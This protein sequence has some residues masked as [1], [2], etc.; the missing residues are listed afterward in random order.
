MPGGELFSILSAMHFLV[1]PVAVFYTA[2]VTAA[3]EHLHDRQIAYRDLK[4]EN[5]LLDAQG[6]LK[7]VDFGFAKEV[8]TKT[9]TLC[10]TPEYLAP[11][12]I[13]NEGHNASADWWA[14]GILVYEML[15]GASP[16]NPEPEAQ[17]E[18]MQ[19]YQR[20]LYGVLPKPKRAGPQLSAAATDLITELLVREPTERLGQ[21]KAGVV[22]IK[23]HAFFAQLSWKHLEK[24]KLEAPFVPS[25]KDPLDCSAFESEWEEVPNEHKAANTRETN[26][27]FRDF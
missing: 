19:I 4:P 16:F 27:L 9:W 20:I 6:Y 21:G 22:A 5:L 11:E 25:C 12:I 23:D 8:K 26:A 10:G 14:V 17:P 13:M 7:V 3:F 18:P 15:M 2:C 1:E 24:R